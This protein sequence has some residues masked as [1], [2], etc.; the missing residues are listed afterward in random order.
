MKL[1]QDTTQKL[2]NSYTYDAMSRIATV[3][4]G[5]NT[6]EYSRLPGTSLLNNVTVKQGANTIVSTAKTYD[7]FNRLLSTASTAGGVTRTY[8]YEYNTKDQ[9]TKLTLADG[10]Y[11]EYTYD[12]KGQVTSGVKKDSTGKVIP[13]QSFGYTFDDIGNR[14]TATEGMPGMLYNYTAN[15]VNQYTQR[16]VPG[17]VPVTGSAATDAT[18]SVKDV[19]NGQV[20]RA[21]RDGKYFS[22]AVP[23]NNTTAAKEANLEINAVKFDAV[24]DKDIVKTV[25]GKYYVAKTPQAFTYDTDGNMTSD[26]AWTYTYNA[27]NRPVTVINADNTKKF[28]YKYDYAGRRIEE[29]YYTSTGTWT[30]AKHL[31]FIYQGFKKI[32]E[33][34][35]SDNLLKLYTWQ[36]VGLDVPLW[37]KDGTNYYYYIAD[38]NKNIRAMVDVSGNEVANYD[39]KPFGGIASK[40]GSYADTNMYRFSSEYY[41]PVLKSSDFGLRDYSFILGR[42]RTRDPIGEKGGYNLYGMVNNDP[43]NDWDYYGQ[44]SAAKSKSKA[45]LAKLVDTAIEKRKQVIKTVTQ[46][47][48]YSYASS[49]YKKA[50]CKALV[51]LIVLPDPAK[52]LEP[53]F[54]HAGVG[55][56]GSIKT[57]FQNDFW[58]Y[59]PT[60]GNNSPG[61]PWWDKMG[62]SNDQSLTSITGDVKN[63]NGN[64]AHVSRR[65]DVFKISICICNADAE[66]VTKWWQNKYKNL[67]TWSVMGDQC[68]TT[69]RDSL[70]TSLNA[71][72]NHNIKTKGVAGLFT[73]SPE[74]YL[75]AL[76]NAHITHGCGSHRGKEVKFIHLNKGSYRNPYK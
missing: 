42:W 21:D 36:P 56:R 72:I 57:G 12:D 67:G 4:D 68:T 34:D 62:G 41:C 73:K 60:N 49:C 27:E 8:T 59:G 51:I 26:G 2:I 1:M 22:K 76:K 66:K 31:K 33:Y 30:L 18:V 44:A 10:S 53:S 17:I 45:E 7:A 23:V 75:L 48:T 50:G 39:Y 35:G 54:G 13:G 63:D 74:Q 11:W 64:I 32:A 55:I 15:N 46:G 52:I 69:V 28:E 58:D 61:R 24:Q 20:Y 25:S 3:S 14:L 5:T 65:S 19:D 37:G 70:N 43:I 29:K 40:S 16:T 9:R 6:A 38:G 47:G 71:S